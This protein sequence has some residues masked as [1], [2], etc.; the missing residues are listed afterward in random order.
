M[1]N[2]HKHSFVKPFLL[3][4][5]LVSI[6]FCF[7]GCPKKAVQPIEEKKAEIKEPVKEPEPEPEPAPLPKKVEAPKP[8]EPVK[9]ILPVVEEPVKPKPLPDITEIVSQY[10][11]VHFEVDKSRLIDEA[12][13]VLQRNAEKIRHDL[14]QYPDLKLLVEGHCDERGTNEYNLSLGERRAF[15]VKDYLIS[16]GVPSNILFTKSWGEEKPFD[17]GHDEDA[18]AK[19]RRA[20]F[21]V[22]KG[23]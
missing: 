23:S 4:I 19:N 11:K 3:P 22:Y 1:R 9:P 12:R 15:R 16:L 21:Q 17:F 14:Q 5:L 7:W 8:A 20:D 6:G 18:W 13:Q 2:L 10:Q